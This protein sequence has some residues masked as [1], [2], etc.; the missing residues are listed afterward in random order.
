M[1]ELV[2]AQV[3]AP[4]RVHALHAVRYQHVDK[5]AAGAHRRSRFWILSAFFLPEEEE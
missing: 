2:A 3:E 5:L 4:Q 1:E